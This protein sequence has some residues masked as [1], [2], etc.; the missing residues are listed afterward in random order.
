MSFCL[1]L[2]GYLFTLTRVSGEL[3]TS[4]V[5]VERI[6]EYFSLPQEVNV[7]KGSFI[8]YVS[9][10]CMENYLILVISKFSF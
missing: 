4:M 10:R 2:S 3:D 8:P 7:E 1:Q 9:L 6:K 5:A